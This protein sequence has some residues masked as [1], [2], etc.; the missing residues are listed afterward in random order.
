MGFQ[1]Y[2]N[3]IT[4]VTGWGHHVSL[5]ILFSFAPI[6]L[7]GRTSQ[8]T[9]LFLISYISKRGWGHIFSLALVLEVRPSTFSLESPLTQCLVQLPTFILSLSMISARLRSDLVFVVVFFLTRIIFH[10]VLI[11]AYALP[12]GVRNGT[13]SGQSAYLPAVFLSCAMPLHLWFVLCWNH[14]EAESD[15]FD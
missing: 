6:I 3:Q 15:L 7:I 2:R 13:L 9:Y 4:A 12:S 10:T 14:L 5:D 8:I 1:F 11:V